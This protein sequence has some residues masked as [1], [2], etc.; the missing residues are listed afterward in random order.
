MPVKVKVDFFQLQLPEGFEPSFKELSEK[1]S[2]LVGRNR[3]C[4]MYGAVIRF[5]KMFFEN[6]LVEGDLIR[7]RMDALPVRGDLD[8]KIEPINFGDE[9]GVAE[10]TAFLFHPASNILLL[11]RNRSGVGSS[12]FQ[13]YF[14]QKGKV[15]DPIVLLPVI[16]SE[17]IRRLARFQEIRK[18]QIVLAKPRMA[19]KV[20]HADVASLGS[21]LDA[22]ELLSS[23]RERNS[24][25]PSA[26]EGPSRF[27][28][29]MRRSWS[30]LYIPKRVR[31]DRREAGCHREERRWRKR[32]PR[33]PQRPRHFRN[34]RRVRPREAVE[35]RRTPSS[36]FIKAWEQRQDEVSLYA[37]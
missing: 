9:E 8:G 22:M 32:I 10:Q 11:Q 1:V 30:E 3:N 5:H 28:S 14:G 26:E 25:F 7:L 13:E 27:W 12:T 21:F 18:V 20:A 37:K 23:R 19:A 34:G 35:V 31:R 16:K 29:G 17:A 2:A 6:N 36:G 4:S 15:P 33:H 24:S